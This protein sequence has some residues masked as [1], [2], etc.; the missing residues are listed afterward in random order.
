MYSATVIGPRKDIRSCK[1]SKRV[2]AEETLSPL[3][4]SN[5]LVGL[6]VL[7]EALGSGEEGFDEEVER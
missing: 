2:V 1:C 4:A 3:N 7:V 5:G 6:V